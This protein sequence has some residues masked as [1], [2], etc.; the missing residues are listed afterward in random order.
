MKNV[1]NINIKIER[2][3]DVEKIENTDFYFYKDTRV[4]DDNIS[5]MFGATIKDNINKVNGLDKISNEIPASRMYAGKAYIVMISN[6]NLSNVVNGKK[7]ITDKD[8]VE[9]VKY[10]LPDNYKL[11]LWN[12]SAFEIA[13]LNYNFIPLPIT[14]D[15]FYI[16]N[17][18]YD[19]SIL[20]NLLNKDDKV[21]NR[22][23]LE[24]KTI[25]YYNQTEDETQYI[26]FKYLPSQDD[27]D[28]M[29]DLKPRYKCRY[30]LDNIMNIK[31]AKL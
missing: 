5:Y 27:Y 19:L 2:T 30:I 6:D 14:F 20:L 25:P 22:D 24:V 17:G 7:H 23:N 8:V 21:L 31:D 13:D 15:Y 26:P 29:I 28:K 12:P 18:N 3:I 11:I 4:I 1:K 16:N 9:M 10:P